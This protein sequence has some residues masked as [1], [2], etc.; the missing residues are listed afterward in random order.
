MSPNAREMIREPTSS[1]SRR[2]L[3]KRCFIGFGSG[4]GEAAWNACV[5][6]NGG[7]VAEHCRQSF[8]LLVEGRSVDSPLG[9]RLLHND[10]IAR[11]RGWIALC[12]ILCFSHS[13]AFFVKPSTTYL[14]VLTRSVIHRDK[15]GTLGHGKRL[16]VAWLSLALLEAGSPIA[17][18]VSIQ[19]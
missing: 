4:G 9:R 16:G 15:V 19:A 7:E 11:L 12:P 14:C 17:N 2:W 8:D 1:R 10:V 18:D 6:I 3:A 13:T 5:I